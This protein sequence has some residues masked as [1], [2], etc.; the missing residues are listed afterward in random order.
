VTAFAGVLLLILTRTSGL[1]GIATGFEIRGQLL[2][3]ASALISAAGIVYARRAL[4]QVNAVVVTAGQMFTGLLLTLPIALLLN[5]TDLSTLTWRAWFATFY[6][7]MIGSYLGF[8]L[9]FYMVRRYGATV[10]ALPA[11]LMPPVSAT[12]GA[13]L[14]GEVITPSLIGGAI[15]ILSGLFLTIQ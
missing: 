12:I 9:L 2:A 4:R 10:A 14:L 5:D 8:L 15:L 7:A 3:L 1:A 11:Y 13:L 6:A